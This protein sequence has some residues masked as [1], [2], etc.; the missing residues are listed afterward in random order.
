[1]DVPPCLGRNSFANAFNLNAAAAEEKIVRRFLLQPGEGQGEAT[2][3]MQR[4]GAEQVKDIDQGA[5]AAQR[6]MQAVAQPRHALGTEARRCRQ[7]LGDDPLQPFLSDGGCGLR[8]SRGREHLARPPPHPLDRE[9][10]GMALFQHRAKPVRGRSAPIDLGQPGRPH[11]VADEQHKLFRRR[12]R[13]DGKVLAGLLEVL[14]GKGAGH[15]SRISDGTLPLNQSIRHR[16]VRA[17]KLSSRRRAVLGA[18]PQQMVRQHAGHHRL[19]HRHGADAD[20]GVVPSFGRD[21]GLLAGLVDRPPRGQNGAG[22]LHGETRDDR[23]TGG[24]AAQTFRQHDWRGTGP[25]HQGRCASRRHSLRPGARPPRILR[26][27]R[28]P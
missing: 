4:R 26:R 15:G 11:L 22:R 16:V 19:S 3:L 24:N 1:M 6:P 8:A 17:L 9:F 12:Q 28:R 10:K 7:K 18:V 2:R 25:R 13:D 5:I 23:L 27:S 14:R 21:L 20:A